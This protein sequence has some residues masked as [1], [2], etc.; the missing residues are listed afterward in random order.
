[1]ERSNKWKNVLDE[2]LYLGFTKK[3][4]LLIKYE[5]FERFISLKS[6]IVLQNSKQQEATVVFLNQVFI[7]V[8]R[9]S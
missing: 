3:H 9:H 2:E 5:L 6:C 7:K 1:M 8:I 4:T